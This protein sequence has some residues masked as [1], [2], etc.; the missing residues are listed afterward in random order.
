VSTGAIVADIGGTNARFGLVNCSGEIAHISVLQCADFEGIDDAFRHFSNEVGQATTQLAIAVACPVQQDRV[1]LTNNHWSFSKK[2]LVSRLKLRELLV[3]NDF[4]AQSLASVSVDQVS[5][6]TIQIGREDPFAPI[7]VIGPGTG[8]GVGGVVV[9]ARGEW[10]PLSTEGGHV[11]M[12]AET[13]DEWRLLMLLRDKYSHVSAERLVSGPGVLLIYHSLCALEGT[14]PYAYSPQEMI[15]SFGEDAIV[16]RSLE[17]F[18]GFFGVVASDGC[19]TLGATGGC[20]IAGGVI[21][22]LGEHFR[23]DIFLER[24]RAK[25]RFKDY[26][27]NIPIKI[28][29]DSKAGLYGLK[30]ALTTKSLDRYVVRP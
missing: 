8:L 23:R 22:K 30:R 24:F 1:K 27:S 26:L 16:S 11:T 20:C 21:P 14:A 19:L 13:E 12:A 29:L 18:A 9:D 4:T 2:Q 5:F 15:V 25:G 17:L 7:F 6:E 3:I 10:T 28:L